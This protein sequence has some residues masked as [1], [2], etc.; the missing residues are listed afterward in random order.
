MDPGGGLYD[1]KFFLTIR[2]VH[3]WEI[4]R[5]SVNLQPTQYSSELMEQHISFRYFQSKLSV[6]RLIVVPSPDTGLTSTKKN[7]REKLHLTNKLFCYLI[8]E[9]N[10][11]NQ[12]NLTRIF[13]WHNPANTQPQ[14]HQIPLCLSVLHCKELAGQ[15]CGVKNNFKSSLWSLV[16]DLPPRLTELQK[17]SEVVSSLTLLRS[18]VNAW[19]SCSSRL[20]F[21]SCPQVC[22]PETQCLAHSI[23]GKGKTR[24]AVFIPAQLL[25][26]MKELKCRMF[27]PSL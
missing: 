12:H 18:A 16:P 7:K 11:L 8:S 1:C 26:S 20:C 2:G 23:F 5:P 13:T 10:L 15:A 9:K 3:P 17:P 14:L 6:S 27:V 21:L 22:H 24:N 4:S 19:V 25:Y